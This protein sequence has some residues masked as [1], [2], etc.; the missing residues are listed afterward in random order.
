MCDPIVAG[1]KNGGERGKCVGE[2][3][4]VPDQEAEMFLQ[5]LSSIMREPSKM[6]LFASAAKTAKG[7][8]VD[9]LGESIRLAKRDSQSP[10][11]VLSL[12]VVLVP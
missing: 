3:R 4:E 1:I 11:P 7:V 2:W 9:V 8:T 12:R 10:S 6:S 5:K